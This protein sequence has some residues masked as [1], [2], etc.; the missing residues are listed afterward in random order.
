LAKA[1]AKL[2]ENGDP[3]QEQEE[4]AR[5]GDGRIGKASHRT[6]FRCNPH[7]WPLRLTC[8]KSLRR[9]ESLL[10]EGE[11]S[12]HKGAGGIDWSAAMDIDLVLG[13]LE[14]PSD[15]PH[16]E[17]ALLAELSLTPAV[18]RDLQ[19]QIV[20]RTVEPARSVILPFARPATI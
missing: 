5:F 6:G 20:F 13:S 7:L 18:N 2:L 17:V 4:E 19:E 8:E 15:R 1:P 14:I 16:W 3:Y 9:L 11:I 10:A 12:I